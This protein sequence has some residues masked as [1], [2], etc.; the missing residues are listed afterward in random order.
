[1]GISRWSSKIPNVQSIP[2]EMCILVQY[3]GIDGIGADVHEFNSYEEDKYRLRAFVR[4]GFDNKLR[5]ILEETYN[6]LEDAEQGFK[7]ANESGE[8]I[9][10]VGYGIVVENGVDYVRFI[11]KA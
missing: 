7:E 8:L 9:D 4:D 11:E 1:M 6:T 3:P 5:C 2:K 10:A